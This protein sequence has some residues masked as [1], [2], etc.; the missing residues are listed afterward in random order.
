MVKRNYTSKR[1][2]KNYRKQQRK[3][4]TRRVQKGGAETFQDAIAAINFSGE[5]PNNVMK[6]LEIAEHGVFFSGTQRYQ[7]TGENNQRWQFRLNCKNA[8]VSN[9]RCYLEASLKRPCLG[10]M[11]CL[12]SWGPWLSDP[13]Q[14]YSIVRRLTN[15]EY[16]KERTKTLKAKNNFDPTFNPS[17]TRG[18]A[19]YYNDSTTNFNPNPT[20]N[21]SSRY[22]GYKSTQRANPY[23]LGSTPRGFR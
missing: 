12:G 9:P 10:V 2:R 11:T 22:R 16:G 17:G 7:L 1:A 13:S 8:S 14:N 20:P 23:F 18:R 5:T 19:T 3:Y 6:S 4:K 15:A 21:S